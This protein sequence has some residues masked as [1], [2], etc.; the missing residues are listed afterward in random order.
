MLIKTD[1]Q[2]Y[3]NIANAI[4]E[5]TGSTKRYK[6]AEMEKALAGYIPDCALSY[7]KFSYNGTPETITV[8]GETVKGLAGLNSM[9]AVVNMP[10][11]KII[12]DYAFC[13]CNIQNIVLPDTITKI[14]NRAF[15]SNMITDINLTENL[16][17][18][19][20]YAF[21]GC[22]ILNLTSLPDNIT[23]IGEQA[24]GLSGITVSSLPKSITKV[25]KGWFTFCTK[26]TNFTFHDKI[27]EIN[28]YPFM[29]CSNLATVTF[30]G[31]PRKISFY[32]FGT[33]NNLTTIN[34]PWSEGEVAGAPWGAENATI[35]YNYISE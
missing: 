16:T 13:G 5:I 12:E 9:Q 34:V 25:E 31:K 23:D 21:Y 35:N 28:D 11:A 3:T 26:I 10:E 18:I 24:F 32:A 17:S 7:D 30:E 33:C 22:L 19:G 20:D 14:G 8:Y 1:S 6:P 15:E 27:E 29:F 4:R 2:N